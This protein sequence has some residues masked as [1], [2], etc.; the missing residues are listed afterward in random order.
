M[1]VR[2]VV[3]TSNGGYF[4]AVMAAT[5]GNQQRTVPF[6]TLTVMNN[7][8]VNT[9]DRSLVT[10]FEFT[11]TDPTSFGYAIHSVTLY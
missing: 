11:A 7:S 3:K 9:L 6:S 10:A 4:G 8:A 5:T 1:T 2:L